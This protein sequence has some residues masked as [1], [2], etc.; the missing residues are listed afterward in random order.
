MSPDFRVMV[1]ALLQPFESHCNPVTEWF[2]R[3]MWDKQRYRGMSAPVGT[4]H[5]LT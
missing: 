5:L 1:A 2:L 3:Q 4:A